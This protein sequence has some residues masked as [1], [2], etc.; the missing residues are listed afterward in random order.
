MTYVQMV[1]IKNDWIEEG[2]HCVWTFDWK[3]EKFGTVKN[4]TTVPVMSNRSPLSGGSFKPTGGESLHFDRETSRRDK[5]SRLQS[6]SPVSRLWHPG[7]D[8]DS[9]FVEELPLNGLYK[10]MFSP[11]TGDE[12][13]RGLRKG[14][15]R[16]RKFLLFLDRIR[17][18]TLKF[19]FSSHGTGRRLQLSP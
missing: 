3:T 19:K 11:V 9:S 14:E 16:E 4:S 13:M 8:K 15:L 5:T 7:S 1:L 18:R 6:F 17:R 12:E 10:V 2:K